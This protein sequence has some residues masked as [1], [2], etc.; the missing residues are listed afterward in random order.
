MRHQ[1]RYLMRAMSRCWPAAVGI[2][3]LCVAVANVQADRLEREVKA[4]A[5]RDVPSPAP[6]RASNANIHRANT[7]STRRCF[8]AT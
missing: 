1:A 3:C 5:G 6:D 7:R 4:A 2:L 8:S